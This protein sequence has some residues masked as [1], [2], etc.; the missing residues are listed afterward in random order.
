ML[1]LLRWR[2][3]R[4]GSG[5]NLQTKSY[6]KGKVIDGEHELYTLSIAVMIGV[7]TSISKTNTIMNSGPGKRWV[8]PNDF[9]TTEKYEFRPKGGTGMPA[10]QLAH[11][12]KFKDYSPVVFAYLRRMYGI[13]EFDFLIS[14]CAN[15]N[16][17]EF[18]SN[19]R[20][21]QFFFYSSDGRYMIKTMTN[22]ES[23]FLR[24]ILPDYFRHCCKNPNTMITRFFGM[25]RVKLY[26]LRRNVKFVIMNSVYYTDKYLQTFYDLKGSSVGR[27]AKP[28][29]AVL[30]DNDLRRGLPDEA[31]ALSPET[32]ARVRKQVESDCEFLTKMQIMDY[33]MLVGVHHVPPTIHT[34]PAASSGGGGG[35]DDFDKN[36]A[37]TG[38]QGSRRRIT[39]D[40]SESMVNNAMG[41]NNHADHDHLDAMRSS[42]S[43]LPS[44]FAPPGAPQPH[45]SD[46]DFFYDDGLDDDESSYLQG[47]DNR[48]RVPGSSSGGTRMSR[49]VACDTELKK[50]ATIEK[51]YWPF[52][53]L[54]DIHG[55]RRLE[56]ALCTICGSKPCDCKADPS[57]LGFHI[58]EFSQPL[59]D[60][61]DGGLE[62]DTSC[63]TLPMIYKGPQGDSLMYEGKIFYMGIID[64]LQEYNSRKL[65]ESHY[66]LM[67]TSG[68][69]EA[70][71]VA[72]SFYAERFLSF[73]DE[74]TKRDVN[75]GR[76][77]LLG[78]LKRN[79]DDEKE[80]DSGVEMT[81][82]VHSSRSMI[83][84]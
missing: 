58:A 55:H 46:V 6:V 13:N 70:S 62:M 30:K 53:R 31:L 15:A 4:S 16:F 63:L 69:Y 48:Q 9:R 82:E 64:I 18:I 56:P 14:V 72:P 79:D 21:G 65:L 73:F 10:H 68:K 71:C 54:Y 57:L 3:K 59:S 34:A 84:L 2:K 29:Q 20:S 42:E 12:F 77:R 50:M 39:S 51:L 40:A 27:D 26:H 25:Y 5:T 11:T 36:I 28:G 60:R 35:G 52:H 17:I 44:H 67:Q 38:F 43:L 19:A 7:R 49:S 8:H 45:H 81:L 23:K 66:R 37:T 75:H 41:S 74:F 61:K 76:R 24:R 1:K 80:K 78:N 33:S 32:R 47:S 83:E 22:A